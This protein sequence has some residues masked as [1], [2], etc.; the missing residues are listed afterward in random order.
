MKKSEIISSIVN[1]KKELLNLL[2][3]YYSYT[4]LD[5]KQVRDLFIDL[6]EINILIHELKCGD[7]Y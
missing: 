3:N 5:I 2:D 6:N 4:N 7:S 1:K